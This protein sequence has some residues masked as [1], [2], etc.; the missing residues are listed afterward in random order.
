MQEKDG[1]P[2][3]ENLVETQKLKCL[4]VQRYQGM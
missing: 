4:Q 3:F 2:S 1:W